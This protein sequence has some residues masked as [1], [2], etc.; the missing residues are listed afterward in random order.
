MVMIV[1][2]SNA[3]DLGSIPG[4]RAV[5]FRPLVF[6]QQKKME[7]AVSSTLSIVSKCSPFTLKQ[8]SHIS[9]LE[10]AEIYKVSAV[11]D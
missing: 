9:S 10:D 7:T 8:L 3:G 5:A 11:R 6:F 4:I 1:V 2:A